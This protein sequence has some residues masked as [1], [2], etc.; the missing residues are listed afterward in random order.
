MNFQCIQCGKVLSLPLTPQKFT[1][2]SCSMVYTGGARYLRCETHAK[3]LAK[4]GEQ[5][6]RNKVLNNNADL[7]YSRV[8]GGSLSTDD[9]EDV[10]AFSEFVVTH[11]RFGTVLDVGCGPLPLP[12]Y[13]KSL[14][15][16]GAEIVGLDPID[17]PDFDGV[18]IVGNSEFTPLPAASVDTV[19]FATSLDH[20]VDLGATISE[21]RR[22]IR[23]GGVLIAWMSDHK[24]SWWRWLLSGLK[25]RWRSL[26][27]G[28]PMHHYRIYPPDVV[29]YIPSWAVDPF[30]CYHE[31][32]DDLT[33]KM[34]RAGFRRTVL[35]Y[36]GRDE[37]FLCFEAV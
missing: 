25:V 27:A 30:H 15:A 19:I 23:P 6:L 21:A 29:V 4:F 26:R 36:R 11:A 32:P 8:V 7:V 12:A 28:Y 35:D 5:Y 3:L 17:S 9:R 13:L 14:K 2:P 1:C 16:A 37:V 24:R 10:R 34:V 33:R 31:N 22:V 20:V 18:R